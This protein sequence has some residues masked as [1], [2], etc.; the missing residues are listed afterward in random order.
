MKKTLL[1]LALLA[2]TVASMT[3]CSKSDSSSPSKSMTAT[4]GSTSFKAT[5]FQVKDT[6]IG[7]IRQLSLYGYT[8]TSVYPSMSLII[9]NY[10]GTTGTVSCGASGS[11]PYFTGDYIESAT[12]QHI[13][14]TGQ[15]NLTT[16]TAKHYAGTYN[17]NAMDSTKV[18]NGAFDINL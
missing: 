6:T 14:L 10:A 11:T 1:S 2:T 4:I 8:G 7:S 9:E 17:F 18:T 13:S 12:A 15:I 3:S 5:S 16:A